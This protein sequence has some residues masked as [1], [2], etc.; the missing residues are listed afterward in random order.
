MRNSYILILLIL[1]LPSCTAMLWDR[2]SYYEEIN[3]FYI[4]GKSNSFV[5]LGKRFHYIFENEKDLIKILNTSEY[6]KYQPTF[7]PF[8]LDKNNNISGK[9]SLYVR[10]KD[11]SEKDI[12]FLKSM[13]F[14]DS[15]SYKNEILWRD[16]S[17]KGTRYKIKKEFKVI[18][19]IGKLFRIK[20][21]EPRT[22]N[23]VELA[24]K[25]LATPVTVATDSVLVVFGGALYAVMFVIN[26]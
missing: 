14:D 5:A 21:I 1:V 2:P 11:I 24:A 10:K 15:D 18:Q 6:I 26:N 20:V 3:S 25:A 16:F 13:G 23:S 4:E 19:D 22:E 7:Y 9:F 17:I 8:S 12:V